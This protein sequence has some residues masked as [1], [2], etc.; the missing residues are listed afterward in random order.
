M[1]FIMLL[2]ID[3]IALIYGNEY[4]NIYFCRT[5]LP[6]EIMGFPDF[7]FSSDKEESFLHHTDVLKYLENYADNFNLYQCIKVCILG[8]RVEAT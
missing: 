6:K 2:F 1:S 3:P 4:V 5:N 8:G 7:P